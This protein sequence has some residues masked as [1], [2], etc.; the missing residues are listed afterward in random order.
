METDLIKFRDLTKKR[1]NKLQDDDIKI[2][3]RIY[4]SKW[5]KGKIVDLKVEID[6]KKLIID[7]DDLGRKTLLLSLS[8]IKLA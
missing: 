5:G 7:F 2:G 6:D 8:P 3:S 4:H 1:V